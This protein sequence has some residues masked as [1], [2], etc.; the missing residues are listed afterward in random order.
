MAVCSHNENNYKKSYT[1]GIMQYSKA[2][3][4]SIILPAYNVMEEYLRECIKS[5]L[6]QTFQDFEIIFV[7]DGSTDNTGKICDNFISEYPD[8]KIQCIHQRNAGQIAARMNGF[9]HSS[10]SH[11][12]FVD[13]DDTVRPDA[14][15]IIHD[16]F[17]K[18]ECDIVMFN[19]I[20]DKGGEK[21]LFWQ[22]YCPEETLFK[23]E[24]FTTFLSDAICS[25]R[26]NNIWLKAFRRSIIDSAVQ[27]EDV[28]FIRFEEDYLM[29][30]PWFDQA[31][32]V[33]YIPE[34]LYVYRLNPTSIVA[35]GFKRFNPN[36]FKIALLLYQERSK[37]A[38][39]WNI[40]DS[41]KQVNRRFMDDVSKA[42]K[43]LRFSKGILSNKQIKDFLFDI[44]NNPAFRKEYKKMDGSACGSQIGRIAL[45]FLY[46][47]M[48]RIALFVIQHDPKIHGVEKLA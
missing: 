23:G 13:S 35:N 30:L 44:C 20:R 18:H 39:K 36:A 17:E 48:W 46:Y 45:S 3:Y 12:L 42:V 33:A 38:N 47:R 22:H 10:G 5:L 29:Q 27:Y 9:D 4:F 19:A 32:S 2:P 7:D 16:A 24:S 11:I 8:V 43:Q 28:S 25:T 41:E 1:K 37:Y 34:N 40:P 6:A 15:Q 14:L 21:S 31:K 26:L